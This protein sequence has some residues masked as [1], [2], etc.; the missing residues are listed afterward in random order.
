[1][2]G[3]T[4]GLY[5]A[6]AVATFLSAGP[7]AA[8][9]VSQTVNTL[10]VDGTYGFDFSSLIASE[11]ASGNDVRF[12]GGALSFLAYS[13]ANNATPNYLFS[14]FETIEGPDD[15]TISVERRFV[16][17]GDYETETVSVAFGTSS[18]SATTI[19]DTS[20]SDAA[21]IITLDS[22]TDTSRV[23]T[24]LFN[25]ND[26]GMM[27]NSAA[28]SATDLD[29]LTSNGLLNFTTT[30]SGNPI[31][32]LDV[33]LNLIYDL[34]PLT[35]TTPDPDVSPVPLPA[36]AWLLSAGIGSVAALRRRKRRAPK[37]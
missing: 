1:M 15:S 18:I 4:G 10:G 9:T 3:Q 36:S 6:I 26:Y 16:E 22:S 31:Q 21:E 32:V 34:V 11:F 33:S 14:M 30:T 19:S 2:F 7:L 13:A 28:L 12:T 27:A 37:A 35:K 17:G 5:K 20:S 23:Y 29:G 25:F 8:A 24:H